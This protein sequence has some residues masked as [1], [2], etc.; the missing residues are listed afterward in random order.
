MDPFAVKLYSSDAKDFKQI[1]DL[2]QK[3]YSLVESLEI[4]VDGGKKI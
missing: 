2:M 1:E 4:A 3:G